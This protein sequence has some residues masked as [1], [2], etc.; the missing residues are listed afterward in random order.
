[1]KLS[2]QD[3]QRFI[4]Q[5]NI[6]FAAILLYGPDAMRVALQRQAL[7]KAVVGPNAEEEMRFSRMTGAELRSDPA[8]LQDALR[9]RGFFPGPRAVLLEEAT[10][11][12][13]PVLKEALEAA[14]PDDA[15]LIVTAGQLT[16]R[17]AL[18]KLFEPAKNAY[19]YAIYD[20][21]PDRR[22]IE[23]M[24]ARAGLPPLSREAFG[25]IE[26]LAQSLDPGDFE[27]FLNKLSLYAQGVPEVSEED[28]AAVAPVS[29]EADSDEVVS[30][31]ASGQTGR[32]PVLMSKMTAQGVTPISLLLAVTRHFRQLHQAASVG[33]P[34]DD[35][36]GRLRPP[37]MGP[38]RR[39]MSEQLRRWS[40]PQ[41]EAALETLIDTDLGLRSAR[42][43]PDT[44]FLE[45]A[46]VRIAMMTA[47]RS[48]GR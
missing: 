14:S 29:T 21:P 44:A 1:M 3:A 32:L 20:D 9:A 37:V 45:R 17:G 25:D 48:A 47:R 35:A 16:P 31:V 23:R 33:G 30:A 46:L 8:R 38:R 5:P 24:I 13:G 11:G 22:D 28:V 42:N 15:F 41:L 6:Q 34:P 40:L 39:M 43:L 7:V 2:K 18:R 10:D 12:L 4:Q 36:L 19:A 26:T 27:Q